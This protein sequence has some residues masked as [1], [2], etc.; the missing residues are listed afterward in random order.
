MRRE[1]WYN[2]A[3][4]K[5]RTVGRTE[6]T[7]KRMEDSMDQI[8][9]ANT[10][11]FLQ[12]AYQN[13][14]TAAL[15]RFYP[16]QGA[17]WTGL[18]SSYEI[19]DPVTL[20][21]WL[22]EL[23]GA[24]CCQVEKLRLKTIPHGDAA[25][26]QGEV[27]MQCS[28][29]SC[30]RR[31]SG[32]WQKEGEGW[33]LGLFSLAP[34]AFSACRRATEWQRMENIR[35]IE[36]LLEACDAGLALASWDET[37]RFEY[38]SSSLCRMLGWTQEEFA[39]LCG[40]FQQLP[41]AG[42]EDVFRRVRS[43]LE[44]EGEYSCEFPL[45]CRDGSELW[46]LS[47][48]RREGEQVS[49]VFMDV[50]ESR[51]ALTQ[52]QVEHA[53]NEIALEMSND[54][55]MEYNYRSDRAVFRIYRAGMPPK[56]SEIQSFSS[57]L[58]AVLDRYVAPQD[59][60]LFHSYVFVSRKDCAF[61]FRAIGENGAFVWCHVTLRTVFDRSGRLVSIVGRIHDV[62]DKK[63]LENEANL[64]ALTKLYNRRY[65][66]QQVKKALEE[67]QGGALLLMDVDYF[68]QIND[69]WGHRTGDRVLVG[70]AQ[71]LRQF[72]RQQDYLCRLGGDEFMVF[73]R[74]VSRP[75]VVRERCQQL[76]DAVEEET[77]PE[78]RFRV[79]LSIGAAMVNSDCNTP[80]QLY[81]RADEALYLM[82]RK[83]KNAVEIWNG[84]DSPI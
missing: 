69:T 33:K 79:T 13:K 9:Y 59:H 26:M 76:L 28:Q 17:L 61:D 36:N 5:K 42:E 68:K 48:G 77:R 64:D 83:S 62:S 53:R 51:N 32:C 81:Q 21:N 38:A 14:D 30:L 46:V 65:M 66:R 15:R 57:Q 18:V 75:E 8:I 1:E 44:K 20:E 25:V 22:R 82:K 73:L 10:W 67:Q 19:E 72:F 55:V 43:Q 34:P 80:E 16:E 41:W 63:Q 52:L 45:R 40:S 27:H 29:A 4:I 84:S 35:K 24:P 74:G 70:I 47:R 2:E 56:M 39:R 71:L 50:T 49:C 31:L 54:V 7:S 60:E 6:S 23:S 37:L 3:D 12:A 11:D 78:G 58:Q